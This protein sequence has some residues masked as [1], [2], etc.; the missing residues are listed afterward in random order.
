MVRCVLIFIRGVALE[1][2][3]IARLTKREAVRLVTI[4]AGNARMEHSALQK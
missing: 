3:A 2:N 4:T 1:A